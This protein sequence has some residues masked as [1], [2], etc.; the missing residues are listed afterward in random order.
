MSHEQ[1]SKIAVVHTLACHI[2]G[3]YENSALFFLAVHLKSLLEEHHKVNGP[4]TSVEME[5]II[6]RAAKVMLGE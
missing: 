2:A 5:E 3:A 1:V 6:A 4:P